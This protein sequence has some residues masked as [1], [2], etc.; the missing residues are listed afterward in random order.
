MVKADDATILDLEDE[1]R[2]LVLVVGVDDPAE[3]SAL[4]AKGFGDVVASGIDAVELVARADRVA[5]F[6]RWLPR[7]RRLGHVLLDLLARDAYGH[8]K[9]LNLNP[10][11]FGLIWRLADTPNLAVSKRELIQDVWRMGFMPETNSIAV[12]MSRLRRKLAFVG[13]DG[14]IETATSGGYRLATPNDPARDLSVRAVPLH[15]SAHAT[16]GLALKH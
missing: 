9:P 1:A 6:T 4:L 3:R 12:H 5:Q 7:Q 14:M 8:G 15:T 2:R 10:R 16:C 11:E 13:L